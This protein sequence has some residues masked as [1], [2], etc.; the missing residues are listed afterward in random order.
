MAEKRTTADVAL[1][2]RL[3]AQQLELS[4]EAQR[5]GQLREER[6]A[7]LVEHVLTRPP[8]SAAAAE[9][10]AAAAA[11][12]GAAAAAEAEAA[13][14]ANDT[15]AVSGTVTT[16][17]TA[18]GT[19][20][21]AS[22]HAAS[23]Q[24]RRG[25]SRPRDWPAEKKCIRCGRNSHRDARDC[26]AAGQT[27]RYCGKVG[28]FASV[29]RGRSAR[30]SRPPAANVDR[31]QRRFDGGRGVSSV[32]VE[33]RTMSTLEPVTATRCCSGSMLQGFETRRTPQVQLVLHRTDGRRQQTAWTPDTGAEVSVTSLDEATRMGINV[34]DLVAPPASSLL[35]VDG[36]ELPCLGSCDIALQLGDIKR[37]VTVS[38]VKKL[39]YRS[40]CS[41]GLNVAYV[42]TGR[43]M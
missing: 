29:C 1:L 11:E 12:A 9:A 17:P 39:V 23:R 28:H 2:T 22:F 18:A 43:Q 5:Q 24:F 42:R 7:A 30:R 35:T 19:H 14:A 6:L 38:V 3:I 8:T 33:T 4:Q 26:R 31:P 36:R 10:G 37:T 32:S 21:A 15:G 16:A 20:P 27:C 40:I 13:A 25:R 34:K 41:I